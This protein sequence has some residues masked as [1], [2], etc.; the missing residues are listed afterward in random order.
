ME[1][2]HTAGFSSGVVPN[3]LFSGFV[4][5]MLPKAQVT[6]YHS[7]LALLHAIESKKV[8]AVVIDQDILRYFYIISP[9]V[10]LM[11]S[12]HVM[13]RFHD[14]IGIAVSYQDNKLHA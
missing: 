7:Q 14:P 13:N 8:D 6:E 3:T 4:A 2:L 1:L 12:A 11:Y 5:Y 9:K 10:T